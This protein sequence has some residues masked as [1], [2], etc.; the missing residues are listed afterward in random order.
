MSKYLIA[1]T[2]VAISLTAQSPRMK[3]GF[4]PSLSLIKVAKEVIKNS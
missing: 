2:L 3:W 4:L 1:S